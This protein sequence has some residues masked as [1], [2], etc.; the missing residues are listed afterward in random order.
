MKRFYV[1][2]TW[3]DWPE[4]GSFGTIVEVSEQDTQLSGFPPG[5]G[6][7]IGAER[8][9]HEEMAQTMAHDWAA[10]EPEADPAWWLA[11]YADQWHIVDCFDLD[12]FIERHNR[13][14]T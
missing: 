9:C 3:H 14:L 8:M 2:A 1:T 4:G 13:R 6:C 7:A 12:E 11:N 10:D 5:F